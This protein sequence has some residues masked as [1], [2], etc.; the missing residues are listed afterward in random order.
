MSNQFDE[1]PTTSDQEELIGAS[2]G[3]DLDDEATDVDEMQFTYCKNHS[4]TTPND[5][6][7]TDAHTNLIENCVTKLET[8]SK[9][10]L[11]GI[12]LLLL[13]STFLLLLIY[14]LYQMQLEL[15]GSTYNAY[16]ALLFYSTVVTLFLVLG[17]ILTSWIYK[18]NV[19]FYEFP[20]PGKR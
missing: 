7:D 17:T 10:A 16:G 5:N 3:S 2:G 18:W 9:M 15:G 19:K 4:P 13:L 14:P 11:F 6:N 1:S 12:G 8:K 20:I